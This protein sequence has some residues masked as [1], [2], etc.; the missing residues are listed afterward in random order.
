MKKTSG[1][2]VTEELAWCEDDCVFMYVCVMADSYTL[3]NIQLD[4]H[5]QRCEQNICTL[6]NW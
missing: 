2:T 1:C 5:V 6:Q 3:F 4:A